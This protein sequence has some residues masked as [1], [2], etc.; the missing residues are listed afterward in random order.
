MK[1]F[2]SQAACIVLSISLAAL[3]HFQQIMVTSS[4][5]HGYNP[6]EISAGLE[7]KRRFYPQENLNLPLN[8]FFQERLLLR[9]LF[10]LGIIQFIN[11]NEQ[12]IGKGSRVMLRDVMNDLSDPS[13]KSDS[14]NAYNADKTYF[15]AK[16]EGYAATKSP[17]EIADQIVRMGLEKNKNDKILKNFHDNMF[18]DGIAGDE[19]SEQVAPSV[20]KR[21]QISCDF[22]HMTVNMLLEYIRTGRVC[23]SRASPVRFGL[24]R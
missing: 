20:N 9:S 1:T 17:V 24:G 19:S 11:R 6:D 22:S 2:T 14:G 7:L 3:I 4:P 18:A 13:T 5:I 23:G 12:E 10:R 21:M 8:R 16:G 15:A